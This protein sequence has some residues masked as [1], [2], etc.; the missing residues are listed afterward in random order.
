MAADPSVVTRRGPWEHRYIPA[1]GARFHV[2]LAGPDDG[3]AGLVVLLHDFPQ[4][5]WA[6]RHQLPVLAQ[7]GHRVAAMDLRGFA[8]SDKPPMGHDLPTLAA[9][10]AG[11]VQSLGAEDAVIIGQGF[12]GLV[13][14]STAVL[15]PRETRGL[16]A[17][18]APHPRAVLRVRNH[19]SARAGA[20][21]ARIQLPYF[22]ER[23]LVRG[24]L[25]ARVLR[26]AAAPGFEPAAEVIDTY[27]SAMKLPSVAHCTLEHLRWLVRSTPRSSG[28]RYLA[29]MIEPLTVPVMTLRGSQDRVLSAAAFATDGEHVRG[30]VHQEV[31]EDA[32]HFLT[33]EAPE[34]VTE[35]LLG[36]LDGT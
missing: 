17:L 18:A 19:L 35:S 11:V 7:A 5:W 27:R 1:N 2:T 14:W 20:F 6:W 16:V 32:G 29:R 8:G 4:F 33:E 12:G 9:D 24:D 30:R 3:H 13:A 36:F 28:R 10:V 23:A 26:G 21:I 34:A 22:P 31:I 15:H 25:V